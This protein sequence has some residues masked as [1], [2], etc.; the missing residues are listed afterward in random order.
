MFRKLL[1]PLDG[2]PLGERAL[3]LA[4]SI[5]RRAAAEL[6]L[7]HVYAPLESGN[8]PYI[9]FD[10]GERT[11]QMTYL[12]K[13]ARKIADA[14]GIRVV[15]RYVERRRVPEG[16]LEAAQEADL[17][18]AAT[19]GYGW[20]A[21]L[22]HGSVLH[23]L[24]DQL[25]TPMLILRG[26]GLRTAIAPDQWLRNVLVPLDGS[27]EAESALSASTALGTLYGASY[28]LVSVVPDQI[29]APRRVPDGAAWT[30]SRARDY[31]YNTAHGMEKNFYKAS[32]RVSATNRPVA[33]AIVSLAEVLK[34]DCIAIARS[35][36]SGFKPWFLPGVTRRVIQL[37]ESPVLVVS[38]KPAERQVA[39]SQFRFPQP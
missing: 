20:L 31:L 37:A 25:S 14:A 13:L 5:A 28:S 23:E 32:F 24:L 27:Q 11:R 15:P 22:W 36:R 38:S 8:Y 12:R 6:Q 2:T 34:A 19:H 17:V 29:V 21:G 3:P 33:K 18:V 35:N 39:G 1:V 26:D 30:Q 7:V 16:L 4:V 10:T 9:A